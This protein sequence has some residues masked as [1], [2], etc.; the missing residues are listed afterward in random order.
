MRAEASTSPRWDAKL[1]LNLGAAGT[2]GLVMTLTVV[3]IL[4]LGPW[5]W[6]TDPA[7]QNLS[8]AL[9]GASPQHPLGTDHLGR[10]LLSRT[11]AGGR[12]SLLIGVLS[13]VIGTVVGTSIGIVAAIRRGLAEA[14][15]MRLVDVLLAVPGMIQALVLVA[16]LGRG[17]FPLIVA[18]GIYSVPIFARVA[19]Q[20]TRRVAGL[21]YVLASRA[22]G[23]S[24]PR[25]VMRHIVPGIAPEIMTIASFRLGLNLL[26][27]AALN[28]FGLGAQPPQAEWG[29]MIAESQRYSAQHPLLGIAPG[30]GLLILTVGVNLLGDG[31][32]HRYDPKRAK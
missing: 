19:Y 26:T 32:R 31:L 1:S 10:D 23:A 16:I 4:I 2:V 28:F 17:I 14:F 18:L 27:G 12:V 15:L 11:L 6:T 24:Q 9:R 30:L 20:S 5:V 3:A 13:V 21:D 25:I 29:I 8:N 22:L 7:V